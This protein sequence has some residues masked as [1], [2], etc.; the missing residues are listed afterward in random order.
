MAISA[1]GPARLAVL[2]VRGRVPV[3]PR[4][5]DRGDGGLI[6]M[7]LRELILRDIPATRRSRLQ[8]EGCETNWV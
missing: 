1:G 6:F 5:Y 3:T 8:G 2:S 7:R 4:V